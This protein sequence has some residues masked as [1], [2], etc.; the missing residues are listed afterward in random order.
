MEK[1]YYERYWKNENFSGPGFALS[2][3]THDSA[4]IEKI[5]ANLKSFLRG[6]VLDVGCGDGAIANAISR[7]QIVTEVKGV[8]ISTTATE[9]ARAKYPHVTFKTGPVT[10]LPFESKSFDVVVAIELI[11]HILDSEQMFKEFNRVLKDNGYLIMTTTDFNLPKKIMIS[12]LFWDKYFYPA[13]PHIRFY[14]KKSLET[15]LN[16]FGFEIV[17]HKWNGSYVKLMPKG[18]IMVAKKK[19]NP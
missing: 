11:E 19:V 14:S 16:K 2:P 3:P 13:N 9:T 17:M 4:D 7:L 5:L 18:Q 1:E 10:D 6:S 15:L 12:L 8:D